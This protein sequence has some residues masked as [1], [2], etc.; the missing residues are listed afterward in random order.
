MH[1]NMLSNKYI[2]IL[3][4]YPTKINLLIKHYIFVNL[5]NR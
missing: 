4:E 1:T 5:I 3:D 2:I